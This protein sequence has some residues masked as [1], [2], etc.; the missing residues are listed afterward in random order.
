LG[1]VAL[2][3]KSLLLLLPNLKLLATFGTMA[4]RADRRQRSSI[5]PCGSTASRPG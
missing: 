2:N 3:A 5:K 4:V 1:L